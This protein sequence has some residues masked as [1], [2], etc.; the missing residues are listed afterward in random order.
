M[1]FNWPCQNK[2]DTGILNLRVL[3]YEYLHFLRS[4]YHFG[5]LN[6]SVFLF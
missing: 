3:A 1:F 5:M 2:H 4:T 6:L